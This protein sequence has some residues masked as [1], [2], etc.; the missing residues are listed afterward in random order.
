[1]KSNFDDFI[2]KKIY[3]H[4]SILL[5]RNIMTLDFDVFLLFCSYI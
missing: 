5:K 1:M 2:L 3:I 4:I